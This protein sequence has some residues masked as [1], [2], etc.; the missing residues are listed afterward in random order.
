MVKLREIMLFLAITGFLAVFLYYFTFTSFGYGNWVFVSFNIVCFSL[1]FLLTGFRKKM[2]RLPNSI[3]VAFIVALFAEM[4]GFPLTMYLFMGVF[5][6]GKMYSLEFLLTNVMGQNLFYNIFTYYIFPASKNVMG[7]GMMLV[8]YGWKQIYQ[9]KNKLVTTG[10]YS[11]IR[12]PQYL[13]FLLITLGLNIQWLTVIT[14][15][16]WPALAVLYF[17]LAKTEEKEVKTKFGEEFEAYKKRVPMF[18]PRTQLN[19][20]PYAFRLLAAKLKFH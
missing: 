20:A 10:L 13:G 18:I 11:R 14:I 3:Y 17:R 2:T 9:A 19:A 8:I 4:Y 1:F 7:I 12:N 16:L 6:I 5:G 15:A